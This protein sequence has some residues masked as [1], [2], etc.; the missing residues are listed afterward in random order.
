MWYIYEIKNNQNNTVYIGK[1]NNPKRRWQ[2]HKTNSENIPLKRAIKKYG[3]ENFTFSIL[4]EF[5][6]EASCHSKEK[7]IIT[8]LREKE[9]KLYNVADGG[10]GI[11]SGKNHYLYGKHHTNESKQK[12]SK[13]HKGKKLSDEHKSKIRNS[14]I[15]KTHSNKTKNKISKSKTGKK[16]T[17]EHKKKIGQSSMGRHHNEKT[18]KILSDK[19]KG[20]KNSSSII[21]DQD[22]KSI[23]ELWFSIP[24]EIRMKFGYKKTFYN[25]Y[26]KDKYPIKI[27]T[28]YQYLSGTLRG[29][30][31]DG[32]L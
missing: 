29:Y 4:Y 17:E 6:L 20:E 25:Q 31:L 11:Y 18:K 2:R 27:I 5:N 24:D 7:E 9:N 30:I 8:E 26:L 19:N 10:D 32:F 16:L 15:G 13:A 21:S 3:I 1:T 23:L 22:L 28:F 14:L 12:M